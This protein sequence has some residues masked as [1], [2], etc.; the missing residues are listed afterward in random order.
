MEPYM[1]EN[2]MKKVLITS[3]CFLILL[4]AT[5]AWAIT[6]TKNLT[7]NATVTATAELTLGVPAI[8]FPATT[9]PA[10]IPANEGAVAVTASALTGAT[11]L[12]TLTVLCNQDLT[13]AASDIIDITNVSW[14]AAGD[15]GFQNGNMSKDAA[16]TA[17]SWTGSG[18]RVGTFT[19]SL[20][21]SWTYAK[22]SYTATATYTLTAP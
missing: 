15:A 11:D 18:S 2:K 10:A 17:G 7:I 21:N 8:N 13:N 3:F 1:G 20:A 12:V 22:G 9:P 6:D 14:I 4:L 16:Q 19:Y 5:T